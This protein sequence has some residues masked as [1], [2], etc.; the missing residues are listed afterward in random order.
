MDPLFECLIYA[1][2]NTVT[3][4]EDC[5]D[6][7]EDPDEDGIT[8]GETIN[9]AAE[10]TED[11]IDNDCDGQIDLDDEDLILESLIFTELHLLPT[12]VDGGYLE[13]YNTRQSELDL[14]S[15]CDFQSK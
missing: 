12:S 4:N 10:E 8:I 14:Q 5:N 3:N 2:E 9:P 6:S 11:S 15:I 7:T 13:L 1:P